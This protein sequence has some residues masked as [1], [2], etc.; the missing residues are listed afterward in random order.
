MALQKGYRTLLQQAASQVSPVSVDQASQ[1]MYNPDV[2]LVDI[3]DIRELEQDGQIPGALHA[4][5]GM[6]E[7]WV[8]PQSP[9]FKPIFG[10][11]KSFILYCDSGWRSTLATATLLEMGLTSVSYLEGGFKGWTMSGFPVEPVAREALV[12]K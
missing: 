6:L 10:K 5:R 11:A 12:L 4:P 9:Y 7:F 1:G 2:V 3:R 8:D